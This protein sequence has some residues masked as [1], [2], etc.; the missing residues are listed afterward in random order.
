MSQPHRLQDL[1]YSN[2]PPID[3]K[4]SL[5]PLVAFL[6]IT[7]KQHVKVDLKWHKHSPLFNICSLLIGTAPSSFPQW[8]DRGVYVLQ[9]LYDDNGVRAFNDLQAE[10]GLRV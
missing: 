8:M 4:K 5:G 6:L 10:Y 1:M 9:D 2:I 3:A 7:V